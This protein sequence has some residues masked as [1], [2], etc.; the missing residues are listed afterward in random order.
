MLENELLYILAPF[1]E[2][3]PIGEAERFSCPLFPAPSLI[4]SQRANSIRADF[5][6]LL[7]VVKSIF[8]IDLCLG[9][10][11]SYNV[12]VQV[13]LLGLFMLIEQTADVDQILIAQTLTKSR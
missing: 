11:R 7:E 6:V 5:D 8:P 13:D 9:Q 10:L 1:E 3:F 12:V 4:L 2:L